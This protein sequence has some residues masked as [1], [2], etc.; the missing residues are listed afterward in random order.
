LEHAGEAGPCEV[1]LVDE[2]LDEA[3]RVVRADLVVHRLRQEQE[4]QAVM[5]REMRHS[6]A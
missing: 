5:S 3:D 6:R 4:P 1:Q 2:G